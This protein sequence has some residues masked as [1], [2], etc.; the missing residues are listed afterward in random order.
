MCVRVFCAACYGVS[1]NDACGDWVCERCVKSA[2]NAECCLCL[3]RGGALKTTDG[4][5]WAHLV[6]ALSIPEV[7]LADTTKRGPVITDKITRARRKLRCQLCQTV[8]GN[9]RSR[10]HGVC[11]QCI[12]SKCCTP[13]HVSCAL[14]KGLQVHT[15]NTL[16]G[17][18]CPQHSVSVCVCVCVC[19][20]TMCVC[21]VE[22]WRCWSVE[23]R[24]MCYKTERK[25]H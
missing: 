16:S 1:D 11:V 20:F 21:R 13:M 9:S 4:G 2:S 14:Y 6:C 17:F 10:G 5:Q 23:R 25:S 8:V 19:V 3:L 18:K 24:C 12:H 22:V 7:S 15:V